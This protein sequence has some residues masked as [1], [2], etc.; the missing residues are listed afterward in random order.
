MSSIESPPCAGSREGQNR[1]VGVD[2][3]ESVVWSGA[4]SL[5][6]TPAPPSDSDEDDEG[7]G[8]VD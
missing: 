4:S 5:I 2:P 7:D 8:D 1:F 6:C 3:E